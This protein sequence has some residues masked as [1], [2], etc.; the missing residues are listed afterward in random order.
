VERALKLLLEE[1][2]A[3][4]VF[5]QVL[6]EDERASHLDTDC[7]VADVKT[8]ADA[9]VMNRGLVRSLDNGSDF[10]SRSSGARPEWRRSTHDEARTVARRAGVRAGRVRSRR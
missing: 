4:D 5:A 3:G 9:E 2:E 1:A 7:V 10:S 6:E 8:F